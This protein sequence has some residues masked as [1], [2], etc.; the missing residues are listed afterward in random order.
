MAGVAAWDLSV[1]HDTASDSRCFPCGITLCQFPRLISLGLNV[2]AT[3]LGPLSHYVA[4]DSGHHIAQPV[5]ISTVVYT[6]VHITNT[7]GNLLVSHEKRS[8]AEFPHCCGRL[9]HPHKYVQ[10]PACTQ[11]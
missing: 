11:L 10:R 9:I 5:Y 7:K 4:N 6:I 8:V 2:F 1:E 3:G